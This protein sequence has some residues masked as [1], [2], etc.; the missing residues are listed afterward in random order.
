[1]IKPTSQGRKWQ[2]T[3]NNPEAVNVNLDKFA[4]MIKELSPDYY[5][6]CEEIATTGTHHFHGFFYSKSPKRFSTIKRLFETAHIEKAYASCK[7]NRDYLLKEGKWEDDHKADTK[8][9]GSFREEG[10]LPSERDEKHP[11]QS[12]LIERI[13]EGASTIEVVEEF[14]QYAMQTRNIDELRVAYCGGISKDGVRDLTV[15]Y[16]KTPDDM[17]RISLVY[18]KHSFRDICRINNY[19]GSKG[20]SFDTY[21]YEKVIVFEDY[22]GQLPLGSFI[23]YLGKYP[24]TL[25][26]RYG[27]RQACYNYVYILSSIS[28]EE[29]YGELR[30]KN[31]RLWL[32][33]LKSIDKFIEVSDEGTIE[34]VEI[35]AEWTKG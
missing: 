14:P 20:I 11:E 18:S 15:I 7:V 8:V 28:P 29:Q 2:L 12:L 5:C 3:L 26:A 16:I 22:Y 23:S 6:L 13:K 32:R 17:D 27:D 24:V 25:P 9:K 35:N 10:I 1:M 33:Y 19:G 31:R 30:T 4:E 34:E 21:K